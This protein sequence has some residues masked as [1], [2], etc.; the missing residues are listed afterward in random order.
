MILRE[1]WKISDTHNLWLHGVTV[2]LVC[3]FDSPLSEKSNLLSQ[4]YLSFEVNFQLTTEIP[5][6]SYTILLGIISIAHPPHSNWDANRRRT[7]VS[8][9]SQSLQYLA[10]CQRFAEVHRILILYPSLTDFPTIL[11]EE[12]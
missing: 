8:R 2:I 12:H 5:W 1:K 10:G 6:K 4:N 3:G 11:G 9:T 7:I